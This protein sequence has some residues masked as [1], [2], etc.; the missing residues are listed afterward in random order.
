[1]EA[2]GLRRHPDRARRDGEPV[3]LSP[4]RRRDRGREP[5]QPTLED[6][7]NVLLEYF[8]LLRADMPELPAIGRMKQLAGQF[9]KGL[10]GGSRFR[11]SIYHSH[12]VDEILTRIEEYFAAVAAGVP[13]GTEDDASVI[14]E[15][16]I[17]DSCEAAY[18]GQ[19]SD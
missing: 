11:T 13:Y 2:D 6:K 14:T 3:D 16:P 15:A 9:T 1:M 18:T 19:D 10:P 7:R 5:F 4:D 12:S 17:L 8:D